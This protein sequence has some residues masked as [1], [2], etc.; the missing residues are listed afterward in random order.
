MATSDWVM[1]VAVS[2]HDCDALM[3]GLVVVVAAMMAVAPFRQCHGCVQSGVDNNGT[4]LEEEGGA[5]GVGG[6]C[7]SGEGDMGLRGAGPG[8]GKEQEA[9]RC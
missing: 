3:V 7:G 4:L 2:R 8:E 5:E 6:P 9:T 1:T